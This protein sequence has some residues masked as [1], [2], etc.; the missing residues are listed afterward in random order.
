MK[1][2]SI[3][4]V[5]ALTALFSVFSV[6]GFLLT[7]SQEGTIHGIGNFLYISSSVWFVIYNPDFLTLISL[8]YKVFKIPFVRSI[9]AIS[10][11]IVVGCIQ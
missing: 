8:N 11:E 9:T 1:I 7:Y 3:L 2:T 5:F 4:G 6:A 10:P